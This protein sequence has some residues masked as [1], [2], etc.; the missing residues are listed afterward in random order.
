MTPASLFE[1]CSQVCSLGKGFVPCGKD[2]PGKSQWW[3]W[4]DDFARFEVGWLP[5]GQHPPARE[6]GDSGMLGS[7]APKLGHLELKLRCFLFVSSSRLIILN[8]G[9]GHP[10]LGMIILER[11]TILDSCPSPTMYKIFVP[12]VSRSVLFDYWSKNDWT[13]PGPECKHDEINTVCIRARIDLW[14]GLNWGH[15][16][17][18]SM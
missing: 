4:D 5:I 10:E 2:L 17:G 11:L 8:H 15:S 1:A 6:W 13:K 18:N 3:H 9:A 12:I 7:S 16:Q 14:T